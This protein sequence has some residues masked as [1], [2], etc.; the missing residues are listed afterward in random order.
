MGKTRDLFKKT[1]DTKGIFHAKIDTIMHINSKR[2]RRGNKDTQKNCTKKLL[3]TQITTT[4]WSL[5]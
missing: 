1:G 2:L 3:M 5:T 4:L